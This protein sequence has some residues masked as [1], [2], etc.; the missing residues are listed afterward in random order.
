MPTSMLVHEFP[1]QTASNDK[2]KGNE[3]A[4]VVVSLTE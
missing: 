2:C 3:K 1:I 4:V